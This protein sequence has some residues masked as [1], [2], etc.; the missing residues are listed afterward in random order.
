MQN[1]KVL[2]NILRWASNLVLL[3]ALI[4]VLI[5]ILTSG[6]FIKPPSENNQASAALQPPTAIV[7]A[8]QE[9]YPPP[10]TPSASQPTPTRGPTSTPKP[11][12]TPSPTPTLTPTPIVLSNGWYLYTDSEAGYSF[13][14]PP[15][16]HLHIS[17]EG[18]L[19][20]KTVSLQF[21]LPGVH[22]YQGMVINVRANPT[23]QSIERIVS[24]IYEGGMQNPPNNLS[25]Q[26]EQITVSGLSAYKTTIPSTNAELTIFIPNGDKIY[27][28]A[29]VH[30]PAAHTVDTKA[31]DVFNQVL[32]TFTINP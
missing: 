18:V 3:G 6:W 21:K 15:D 26:I 31:L 29:P 12:F 14:Y 16:T 27:M 22:G 23:Q 30:S 7:T 28:F 9:P 20:Y 8:T 11:T 5:S 24:Q 1:N 25:A 13:S 2:R 19:P 17:K 32:E 10:G 4:F